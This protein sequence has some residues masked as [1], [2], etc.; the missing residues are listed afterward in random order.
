MSEMVLDLIQGGKTDA[1]DRVIADAKKMEEHE[2]VDRWQFSDD[3]CEAVDAIAGA[4][5][6]FELVASGQRAPGFYRAIDEV[7]SAVRKA[8]VISVGRESI[9]GAYKTAQVWPPETRVKNATYWAHYELRGKEYDRVREKA[10]KRLADRQERVGPRDVRLWKSS[11]KT[12][13]VTPFL[14]QVENR[15]RGALKR[16]VVWSHIA[17]GDRDAIVQILRTLADEVDSGA[18]R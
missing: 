12:T 5:N 9:V 8:G 11:R 2:E 4:Q 3:V 13:I 17:D 14:T 16:G 7:N 18:F 10:L 6:G 15:L 1:L